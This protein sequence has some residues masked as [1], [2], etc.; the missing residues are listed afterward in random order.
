V[1]GTR[2]VDP[3]V[4]LDSS[5][6]DVDL[7]C[8]PVDVFGFEARQ[9]PVLEN[10]EGVEATLDDRSEASNRLQVVLV[11]VGPDQP[12]RRAI[13]FLRLN[14]VEAEGPAARFR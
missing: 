12:L 5:D 7:R 6:Q 8:D 9:L 1:L 10:T 11:A 2:L 4:V 14:P 13:A 3:L